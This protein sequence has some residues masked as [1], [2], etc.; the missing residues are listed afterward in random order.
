M[1]IKLAEAKAI[2][3]GVIAEASKLDAR[4]SVAVCDAGGHL[5]AMSRM[6]GVV[7]IASGFSVGKAI[8]SA[9]SGRPSDEVIDVKTTRPDTVIGQAVP[10]VSRRGGIPIFRAGILEG[11]CGV[12]GSPNNDYDY[13]FARAG[14]TGAGFS[15]VPETAV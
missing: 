4:V 15:T 11:A 2:I 1:A 3:D 5:V 10:A 13:T 7:T 9:A 12:S 8:V 14:V 6:D